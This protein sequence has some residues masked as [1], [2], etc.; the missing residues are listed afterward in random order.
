M[1]NEVIHESETDVGWWQPV[2]FA[3]M[4]G[5]MGWG[6][7][8]QYG[9][10]T[11]A[12]IAGLLV[13]LTLTLL[14]CPRARSLSVA[15]AVALATVAIG[16]GG[17]MT[18]G[19]TIGL[20]QNAP[21]IGNW[22]ALRWGM[23]GLAIKGGLW[24]GFA[25]VFLGMGLG[26]IRYHWL[27]LL[28]LMF[29]VLAACALGLYLLNSPFYPENKSLP[30]VYFSAHWYWEPNADIKT[31]KPRPEFWGGLLFALATVVAYAGWWR[32]DGL[33]LR[34][35]GWGVL[36]GAIGFP[37]GQCLQAYHAW[38]VESF[39]E[40]LWAQLDPNMNWWNM[41]E[42]TFGATMGATL[43]LG[44]WL[45]RKRIRFVDDRDVKYLPVAV[46]WAILVV[47][48]SL[49][50]TA[51]FLSF[52]VIEAFYDLGLIIGVLPI[53]AVVG[54]R[55]WP[56]LLALPVTL[57]PITGKT[58]RNLVYESHAINV[59]AGWILYLI[60]PLIIAT[61][62]AVW[63]KRQS[64]AGQTGRDF[65]RRALLLTT[66]IYF[67]LNFAFFRFPW[68]WAPWTGRTPNGI[69]FTICAIGLTVLA[70]MTVRR[71]VTRMPE[72]NR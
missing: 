65:T 35:A 57:V 49:L 14:L 19:Q 43:G 9:H 41:M 50:V 45:H 58:V 26:G 32:K 22:E 7:R 16:F 1:P 15:R 51:E 71:E 6:I 10:E 27:E 53:M 8:G 24:I 33:A 3:A 17:T 60:V 37:L 48:V 68:P 59:P 63:F 25:G 21:M 30:A 56:Y 13:S 28:L 18:Y 2:L 39:S 29:G 23:L 42:T 52:P 64:D 46:E 54:G 4:A 66:W 70:V 47:H 69:I 20:T 44:L 34:L 67:L 55:W 38:N 5:G 36:G 61:A 11:G 62:A 12:M 40:G 72:R 31:L